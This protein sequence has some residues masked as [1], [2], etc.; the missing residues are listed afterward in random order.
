M[1]CSFI[2]YENDIEENHNATKDGTEENNGNIEESNTIKE[3]KSEETIYTECENYLKKR[4]YPAG[5]KEESKKFSS[6]RSNSPLQRKRW[7][8]TSSDRHQNEAKDL[9]GLS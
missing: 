3:N 2:T 6:S 8:T 7:T 4:G 9:R 1:D 5:D